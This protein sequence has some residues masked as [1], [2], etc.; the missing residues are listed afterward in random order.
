MPIPFSATKEQSE[1]F[2]K[3]EQRRAFATFNRATAIWM[4]ISDFPVPAGPMTRVL[5]PLS[6]R[7]PARRRG[8]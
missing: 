2:I 3:D 1:F 6:I 8:E 5:D 4:T 7:R